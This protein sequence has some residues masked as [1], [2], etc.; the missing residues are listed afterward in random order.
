[1]AAVVFLDF[2]MQ[3]MP[4]TIRVWCREVVIEVASADLEQCRR[5]LLNIDKRSSR[6]A[7]PFHDLSCANRRN[8]CG[9]HKSKSRIDIGAEFFES[10]AINEFFSLESG[11]PEVGVTV[12]TGKSGLS[13][14]GTH[15]RCLAGAGTAVDHEKRTAASSNEDNQVC[16]VRHHRAHRRRLACSI[17]SDFPQSLTRE[18]TAVATRHLIRRTPRPGAFDTKRGIRP[19]AP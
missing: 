3:R 2:T 17:G 11:R 7:G 14:Y 8:Q 1:V 9:L 4:S 10:K 18:R 15:R 12:D 6:K 16:L 13:C 19:I 5:C